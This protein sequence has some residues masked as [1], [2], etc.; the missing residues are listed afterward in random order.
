M[1]VTLSH[2]L[3]LLL[4]LCVVLYDC[5]TRDAVFIMRVMIA[6]CFLVIILSFTAGLMDVLG[7][8]HVIC[9]ALRST[10][11][12]SV[13]SG[14]AV[15]GYPFLVQFYTKLLFTNINLLCANTGY[16]HDSQSKENNALS[17]RTPVVCEER[18]RSGHCLG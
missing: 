12:L 10:A 13:L 1:P 15:N 3:L 14:A 5:V 6:S 11:S 2:M 7:P 18:M 16:W 4:L 17:M 9:Q 8:A